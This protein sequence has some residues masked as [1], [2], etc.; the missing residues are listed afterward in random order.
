MEVG[1]ELIKQQIFFRRELKERVYWF[2]KLRWLGVAA[3]LVCLAAAYHWNFDLPLLPLGGIL[4]GV[5][6]YNLVFVQVGARLEALR[7]EEVRSFEIF[8]HVQI[9]MDLLALYLL[10]VFTGGPASPM[11]IFVIFPVVLAGILLS[12]RSCYTYALLAVLAMGALLAWHQIRPPLLW[13]ADL[14]FHWLGASELMRNL[15]PWLVLS[16]GIVITAYLVS[17]VKLTLRSKGRELLAISKQLDE[18]NSKLTSLYE[19]IKEIDAHSH[20]QHLMDSATRQAARI[21]GVKACS[22]KLLDPNRQCLR[23]ASTYGLSEDYLSSDC[24]SIEKSAVNR[25]IIEGSIYSIGH[26][27][28]E[29]Y[30]QYPENIRKEGIASM[31]CLPMRVEQKI[32]GVFCVYSGEQD[33]FGDTEAEFF[34][35]MTD[36]TS[37][38]L[39]RLNQEVARTWFLNK[40]AHQLRSPLNA[41]M[42]MLHV[43]GEEYL[44]K[45][46]QE[47]KQTIGR[48]EKRLSIFLAVINDLLK[49][50]A[51]EPGEVSLQLRPVDAALLLGNLRPLFQS[52]A[53]AKGLNLRFE[54]PES[55][56]MV[57]G[58][59]ALLDDLFTNLISNAVKYSNPGGQVTVS[60]DSPTPGALVFRVVDNGI[61]IAEEEQPRLF[62]QFFRAQ[63]AKEMVEEGTGLGLAIAKTVVDRLDGSI[64]LESR[65][66]Q[67]TRVTCVLP[68]AE[69]SNHSP[70]EQN[71]PSP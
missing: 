38:A 26:I 8:A 11:R 34:S 62:S 21:M 67:G 49:L 5:A 3:G 66:G 32:L 65:L 59:E 53:V 4:L 29:S 46:N 60:L 52:E 40:T 16:A 6:L 25:Q 58:Q 51:E 33:F 43:L 30:F 39:E 70:R 2:V 41:V 54:I 20:L 47:Q 24:I 28:E 31:L 12:R 9:S 14:G 27:D 1:Y 23:F 64:S 19:M 57:K 22:I 55:L 71:Q 37:L 13:P 68:T 36:L 50:A 56:P 35:L 7:A 48:C 63:N 42:S 61:G 10:V 69:A 15:I 17:S 18:S 44:G 45:L